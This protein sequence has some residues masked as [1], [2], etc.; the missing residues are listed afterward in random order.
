MFPG[1]SNVLRERAECVKVSMECKL[2]QYVGKS[3]SNKKVYIL[4]KQCKLLQTF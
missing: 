2:L 4:K 1:A 3:N